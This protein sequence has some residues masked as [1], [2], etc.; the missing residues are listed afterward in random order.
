MYSNLS[1]NEH[2]CI[3]SSLKCSAFKVESAL[4]LVF[5]EL[6]EQEETTALSRALNLRVPAPT[7]LHDQKQLHPPTLRPTIRLAEFGN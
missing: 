7:P 1:K 5:S 6:F 3:T 2:R 4:A